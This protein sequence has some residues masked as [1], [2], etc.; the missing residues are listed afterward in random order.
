MGYKILGM[1]VWNGA[2]WYLRRNVNVGM[3]QKAALVGASAALVGG[4]IVAGRQMA[5][6]DS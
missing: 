3:A 6:D 1:V 4:A 5:S 2:K